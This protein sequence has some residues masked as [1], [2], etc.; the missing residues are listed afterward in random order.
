M[1]QSREEYLKKARDRATRRRTAHPE[2][3]R[4][5]GRRSYVANREDRT[6]KVRRYNAS[7]QGQETRQKYRLAN[8]DKL[9]AARRQY[10]VLHPEQAG[11]NVARA[12]AWRRSERGRTLTREYFRNRFHT[13]IQHRLKVSLRTRLS[14]AIKRKCMRDASVTCLGC[15]LSGLVWHLESLFQS[16]MTWENRGRV[17]WHIDHIKPLAAFDL[18]DPVQLG[19]ACHYTNLQPLWA[20]NM[21]KRDKTPE[22]A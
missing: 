1:K 3:V 20:D 2:L 21:K 18:T 11:R 8:A 14:R 22:A 12:A 6:A 15:T 16:G 17:G 19:A 4:E 7:P 13:D 10:D 9:K 5:E